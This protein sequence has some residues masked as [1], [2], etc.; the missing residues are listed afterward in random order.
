MRR[1]RPLTTLSRPSYWA[2]AFVLASATACG[3]ST[4][5]AARGDVPFKV[6]AKGTAPASGK[7]PRTRAELVRSR[8][9]AEKLLVHWNLERAVRKLKGVDFKRHRLLIL[10]ARGND[11]TEH[12]DITRVSTSGTRITAAGK[13]TRNAGAI[14]NQVLSTPYALVTVPKS[15]A[16][17]S[18]RLAL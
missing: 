10:V 6:V 2:L 9:A 12:L 8:A 18:A 4:P 11:T 17:T 16:A 13:V 7:E 3:S 14:G 1:L 5:A 15:V